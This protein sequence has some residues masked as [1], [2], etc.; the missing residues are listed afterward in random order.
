MNEADGILERIRI[1]LNAKN[2][3][4][5]AQALGI[6]QPSV[7]SARKQNKIP[8]AWVHKVAED[9]SVSADWLFFGRGEM[10]VRKPG[11]RLPANERLADGGLDTYGRA[12]LERI[13]LMV[14]RDP[15]KATLP[16]EKKATL[17]ASILDLALRMG[18]NIDLQILLKSFDFKNVS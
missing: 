10:T 9:R 16:L 3:T 1:A 18:G 15:E 4:G 13:Y 12:M 14:E 2:D 11:E 5:I 17:I 8:P 7:A 6:K